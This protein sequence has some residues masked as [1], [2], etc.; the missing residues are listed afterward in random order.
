M[1]RRED[2]LAVFEVVEARK[3]ARLRDVL[4]EELGGVVRG[5]AGGYNDPCPAVGVDS[6]VGEL[7]KY[8][9]GVD[10]AAAGEREAPAVAQELAHGAGGT[11]RG[12]VVLVERRVGLGQL[13]DEPRARRLCWSRGDARIARGE[14][15]LLLQLYALPRRVGEDHIE[16]AVSE[17]FRKFER[18]MKEALAL[19]GNPGKPEQAPIDGPAGQVI[20]QGRGR[21]R[22]LSRPERLEEGGGPQVAGLFLPQPRGV[23]MQRLEA[24][25]LLA[26]GFGRIVG[27]GV[28]RAGAAGEHRHVRLRIPVEKSALT[29]ALV[30]VVAGE[31]ARGDLVVVFERLEGL[32]R[33]PVLEHF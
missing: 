32:V 5:D 9:V 20:G 23:A 3:R 31:L 27:D 22:R 7:G 26:D 12:K 11:H 8:R 10:V 14:E 24:P 25:P 28:N 17:D 13:A 19:G 30:T 1:N 6:I 16:A 29:V 18:P 33:N 2:P 21:D 4:E 15:L